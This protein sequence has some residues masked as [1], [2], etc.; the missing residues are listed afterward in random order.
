MTGSILLQALINSLLLGSLYALLAIGYSVVYG[1]LQFIN[2]SHSNIFM[3]A[4][5]IPIV[6]ANF[7]VLPWPVYFLVTIVLISC[8]GALVERVAFRP[9]RK[10]KAPL[11]SSL[12]TA[13]GVSFLLE[14]VVLLVFTGAPKGFPAPWIFRQSYQLGSTFVPSVAIY[15]IPITLAALLT[16]YQIIK[17]TKIGLAMRAVSEDL[18]AAG[19]M[20]IETNRVIAVAFALGSGLA[21]VAAFMWSSR[22]TL[23]TPF[24]GSV[25]G[26]KAFVAAV[27]GGVGNLPGALLGGFILGLGEITFVTLVPQLSG[28][29]DI[30]AF[31]TLILVLLVKPSGLLGATVHEEKL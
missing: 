3:L 4:A 7:R 26:T 30:V 19:L 21:A 2:F 13:I 24:M 31:V 1:I 28:Y 22:V 25:P 9:L 6:M 14:N 23:A 12:A 16:L 29:R 11:L 15:N 17:R 8:T 20:G 5:Y 18:E 10:R 27:L